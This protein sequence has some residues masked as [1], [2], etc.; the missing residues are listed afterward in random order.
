M[1]RSYALT[2]LLEHGELT[3]HEL[4]EITGWT[5]KQ[6][7]SV[8]NYLSAFGKIESMDRKWRIVGN[9]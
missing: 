1:T 4:R 3:R 2:K 8:I 6:L 9:Q 7:L 5:D